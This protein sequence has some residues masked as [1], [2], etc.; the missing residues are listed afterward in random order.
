MSQLFQRKPIAALIADT[1]GSSGLKRMLGAGDLIM[2]A[3]GAVIG[4]GIFGAIGTAAA[5]QVDAARPSRSASAPV[6]RWCFRSCCCGGSVRA[7]RTLLRGT[8][9]DD[10]AGGQRLRLLVRDAR[11]AGG[12]DHRLGSDSGIRRR[13]RGRR[14]LV[15]RLL[16]VAAA[17]LGVADARLADHRLSHGAAQSRSG[18]ARPARL[19]R[20]TLRAFR[21]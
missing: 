19:P 3:I 12:V 16:Q 8:G 20:R 5:G 13:Q 9:V 1:E 2:L 15:G 7:R 4:A 14:D 6:R 21:F 10:S 17:R 11:R 18:G